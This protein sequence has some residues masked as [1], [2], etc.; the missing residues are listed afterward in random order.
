MRVQYSASMLPFGVTLLVA[1]MGLAA[2][3]LPNKPVTTAAT[4]ASKPISDGEILQVL[5]TINEGEIKQAHVALQRSTNQQVRTTAQ[6]IISDHNALNQQLVSIMPAVG[7][8]PDESMLSRG[9]RMQTNAIAEDLTG[10]SGQKLDCTYLQK[11]VE[12]HALSIN[13]IRNQ[14]LPSAKDPHVKAIL[15]KAIPALEQHQQMAQTR[16]SSIGS[17]HGK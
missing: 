6:H 13:T 11:Q 7:A 4:M 14:L 3:S 1:T 10:M 17:C 12:Q 16:L 15:G 2:C 5:Q 8:K 9:L